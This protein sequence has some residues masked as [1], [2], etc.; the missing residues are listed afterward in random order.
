MREGGWN[1][2]GVERDKEGRER[3]IAKVSWHPSI[4]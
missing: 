4:G 1:N 2:F 3:E